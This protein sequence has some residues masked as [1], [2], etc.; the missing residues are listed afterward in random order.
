M[1][2]T[3]LP[4]PSVEPL[5][6][7]SSV[8]KRPPGLHKTADP[9]ADA[10]Y[11]HEQRE[12][13]GHEKPAGK[14]QKHYGERSQPPGD[15]PEDTERYDRFAAKRRDNIGDHHREEKEPPP[16]REQEPDD[17]EKETA[18]QERNQDFQDVRPVIG[19]IIAPYLN[20]PHE[21]P[22]P[23]VLSRGRGHPSASG[24]P[25]ATPIPGVQDTLDDL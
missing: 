12:V 25:G 10:R 15:P 22:S 8:K 5:Q 24:S 17:R 20:L 7:G 13:P 3:I 14:V 2:P 9:G 16:N 23:A 6:P 1:D 11:A 18:E 4:E 21:P 19:I